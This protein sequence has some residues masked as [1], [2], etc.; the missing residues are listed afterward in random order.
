VIS[1]GSPQTY[2]ERADRTKVGL[3]V[4]CT[5]GGLNDAETSRQISLLSAEALPVVL[6]DDREDADQIVKALEAGAR[7]FIPSTLSLPVVVEA[8]RFVR[9]GGT[10][11]PASSLLASRRCSPEDS[12]AAQPAA[13][14][15]FSP[16]Q[17]A[18]VEALMF[19][20]PPHGDADRNFSF[21]SATAGLLGSP[22]HGGADRNMLSFPTWA[23]S[24]SRPLTGRGS[25]Q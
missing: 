10:F 25:K 21:C 23:G 4:L 1:F 11:V 3:I 15:V 18:V 16:R 12:A 7:G 19:G 9:A 17:V 20:S 22:P 5:S 2:L 24:V 13:N 14:G 6:I 8:M